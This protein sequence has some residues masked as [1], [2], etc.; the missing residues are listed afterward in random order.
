MVQWLNG[1]DRTF[2]W[3]LRPVGEKL[4]LL[5][6]DLVD[7]LFSVFFYSQFSVAVWLGSGNKITWL[8]FGKDYSLG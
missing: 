6:L 1:S 7:L 5:F 2:T 4:D 3:G 8:G